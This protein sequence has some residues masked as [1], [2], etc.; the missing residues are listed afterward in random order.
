MQQI[1]LTVSLRTEKGKG[2]AHRIRQEGKIPAVLYGHGMETRSLV[3]NPEELKKILTGNVGPVQITPE[4]LLVAAILMETA[5]AMVLLS[6]LLNYRANRWANIIA[7]VLHT[8]AVLSSIFVGKP[9]IYYLF[10]ITIEVACTSFIVWYAWRWKNT[11]ISPNNS[12]E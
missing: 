12:I 9:P 10:F 7:G 5:I 4:F 11:E 6:R 8:A 3:I 2:A 1:E